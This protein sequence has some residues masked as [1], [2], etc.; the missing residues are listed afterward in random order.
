MPPIILLRDAVGNVPP[1]ILSCY[2]CT[3]V[4]HSGVDTGDWGQGD[5]SPTCPNDVFWD[6]SD[7]TIEVGK[8]G[9][10]VPLCAL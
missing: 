9:V 3:D 5:A 2:T 4:L 6:S 10:A 7:M 1:N 8:W